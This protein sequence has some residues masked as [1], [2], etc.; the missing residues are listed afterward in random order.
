MIPKPPACSG[1][2]FEHT[3]AFYVPDEVNP[4]AKVIVAAQNP[5]KDEERGTRLKGYAATG[6]EHWESCN[7]GP[8]IG[9]SGWDLRRNYLPLAGL[10]SDDVECRNVL[11]CRFRGTND[12]PP[13][14]QNTVRD[15]IRHCQRAYWAPPRDGQVLVALGAYALWAL[16]GEFGKEGAEEDDD[17]ARANRGIDGWRGW[18]LDYKPQHLLAS[19]MARGR[20]SIHLEQGSFNA[21]NRGKEH[22]CGDSATRGEIDGGPGAGPEVQRAQ[23]T[24]DQSSI[25]DRG[26]RGR[27]DDDNLPIDGATSKGTDPY[28]AGEVASEGQTA[29]EL[30]KQYLDVRDRRDHAETGHGIKVFCT[31]HPAYFFRAHWLRAVGKMDWQRLGRL[32]AGRWPDPTPDIVR[33]TPREWPGELAFDT[34]Y[35]PND[36]RLI[37]YSTAWRGSDDA[38]R[39]HVV[40]ASDIRL[41]GGAPPRHVVQHNAEA[42]WPYLASV[43]SVEPDGWDDTM[44]MHSVLYGT[45]RHTLDFLGSLYARTNRWKHLEQSEPIVYSGLDALGTWDVWRALQRE[46]ARDHDS[47]TVYEQELKPLLR[48]LMRRPHIRVATDR[49]ARAVTALGEQQREAVARAQVA[50]GWPINPSSA[51]QLSR[52]LGLKN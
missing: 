35:W 9:Q 38:P 36:G 1:C 33:D 37:R 47:N 28:G 4:N 16:T 34:E 30:S 32:L 42:D 43:F 46:L 12:L 48:H 2:P 26:Q 23:V 20:G 18:V 10:S 25:G 39:V 17:D 15:A 51:D 3:G 21:H 11:R 40:E 41:A 31:W 44:M 52:W 8:L 24:A 6:G 19:G 22:R 50:A 49:V 27:L 29:K 5:G 13:L 7:P 45:W 14:G